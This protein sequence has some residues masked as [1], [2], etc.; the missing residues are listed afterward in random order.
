MPFYD[1]DNFE[2]F[3]MIKNCEYDFNAP[4]WNIISN[5]A[6]DFVAEIMRENPMDRMNFTQMMEHPWM[7][8]KLDPKKK[9][10]LDT[11]CLEHLQS[12]KAEKRK[13]MRG[14]DSG[15]VGVVDDKGR[16]FDEK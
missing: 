7:K 10:Q 5:E 6:K 8:I 9:L 16:M 12:V 11:K 1:E 15:L 4:S 13:S 2:M 3:E 14:E